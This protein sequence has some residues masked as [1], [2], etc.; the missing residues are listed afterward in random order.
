MLEHLLH[1]DSYSIWLPS[2][3][4]TLILNAAWLVLLICVIASLI[5]RTGCMLHD[6]DRGISIG[7][8]NTFVFIALFS[9]FAFWQFNKVD[10]NEKLPFF[11][12]AISPSYGCYQ[13]ILPTVYLIST[14]WLESPVKTSRQFL[15]H[16]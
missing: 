5:Y 10:F 15:L 12:P 13:T 1:L 3:G 2:R 4:L 14:A 8:L 9:F 16:R 6:S 7:V 11:W